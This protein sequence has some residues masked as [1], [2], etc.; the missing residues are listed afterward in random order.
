MAIEKE[1]DEQFARPEIDPQTGVVEKVDKEKR[2]REL[3]TKPE[4]WREQK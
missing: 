4:D 1:P 2:A 3:S